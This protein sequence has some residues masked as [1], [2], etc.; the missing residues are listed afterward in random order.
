MENTH[1]LLV[2]TLSIG[3]PSNLTEGFWAIL[4]WGKTRLFTIS[5]VKFKIFCN[6]PLTCFLK[7]L[8]AKFYE[9][10]TSDFWEIR[11]FLQENAFAFF[12]ATAHALHSI[13]FWH[14]GEYPKKML[15]FL[16]AEYFHNSPT[17]DQTWHS[18]CHFK[19]ENTTYFTGIKQINLALSAP[20]LLFCNLCALAA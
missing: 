2:G 10:L 1:D 20:C 7:Y 14:N 8:S 15:D 3:I 16:Y 5:S 6:R 4:C 13:G 9:I 11:A 17:K 19:K 12:R 18:V